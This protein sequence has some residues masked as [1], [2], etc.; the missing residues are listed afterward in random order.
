MDTTIIIDKVSGSDIL[1]IVTDLELLRAF[2]PKCFWYNDKNPDETG[3]HS[4]RC[5]MLG[6][7]IHGIFSFIFSEIS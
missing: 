2:H 6:E 7:I 5:V 4:F 1:Q 3:S